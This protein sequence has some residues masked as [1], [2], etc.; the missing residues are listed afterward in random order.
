MKRKRLLNSRCLLSLVIPYFICIHLFVHCRK[1]VN[2]FLII[3]ANDET[4]SSVCV[5]R[6]SGG[7]YC[8]RCAQMT[9]WCFRAKT[10]RLTTFPTRSWITLLWTTGMA[11][12]TAMFP[13]YAH[14]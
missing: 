14:I 5:I 8:R 4:H 2:F 9:A 10:V 6:S 3:I 11:L 13:R 1:N 12:S 7:G